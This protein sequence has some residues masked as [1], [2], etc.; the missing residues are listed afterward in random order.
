M[1]DIPYMGFFVAFCNEKCAENI[2]P[3]KALKILRTRYVLDSNDGCQQSTWIL[4]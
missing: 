2:T 4:E 1:Q 3:F